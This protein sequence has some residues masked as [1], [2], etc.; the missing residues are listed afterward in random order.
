MARSVLKPSWARPTIRDFD[1]VALSPTSIRVTWKVAPDATGQVDYGTTAAM[2]TLS[3]LE[4]SALASHQQDITVAAATT[5]YVQAIS[6]AAG[7]TTRSPVR[8]VTTPV[9]TGTGLPAI[10]RPA[11][12]GPA[13]APPTAPAAGASITV[14]D[15]DPG[16]RITRIS[17]A[18]GYQSPYPLV[19]IF[20]ADDT[21]F[22]IQGPAGHLIYSAVHPFPL[23]ESFGWNRNAPPFSNVD[24]TILW[25]AHQ[26]TNTVDKYVLGTGAVPVRTFTGYTIVFGGDST[27]I[28]DDDRSWFL[29]GLRNDG[30]WCLILYNPRDNVILA[31]KAFPHPTFG[32][33]LQPKNVHTTPSGAYGII[34]YGLNMGYTADRHGM[35][36]VDRNLNLV[37]TLTTQVDPWHMD[38]NTDLATGH[39][40]L[41]RFPGF[42]RDLVTNAE[43]DLFP[44]QTR[45]AQH[46]SARG[47]KGWAT[48]SS[49]ELLNDGTGVANYDM[50]GDVKLDGS[51]DYRPWHYAHAGAPTGNWDLIGPYVHPS[52]DGRLHVWASRWQPWNV[53]GTTVQIYVTDKP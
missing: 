23:V 32:E 45:V 4:A 22:R 30:V 2:G 5:Y 14:A 3:T 50:V 20:N 41:V 17:A 49:G 53:A 43:W 8:T 39:D 19:Q 38:L 25:G 26:A 13:S 24:A 31:E 46:I 9:A 47:L 51:G 12:T 27:T 1:V 36:Q 29:K 18:A 11:P 15:F 52:H 44:G 42:V 21:R 48:F 28:A 34:T 10:R 16:I 7:K 37:R 40:V 35:W 6:T 33:N